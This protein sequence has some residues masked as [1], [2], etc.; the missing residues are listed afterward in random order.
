[1]NLISHP[2]HPR[3]CRSNPSSAARY[4]NNFTGQVLRIDSVRDVGGRLGGRS[5]DA[6]RRSAFVRGYIHIYMYICMYYAQVH[7]TAAA[8][9]K[10]KIIIQKIIADSLPVNRRSDDV[11]NLWCMFSYA[12]SPVQFFVRWW[13][14]YTL[15]Q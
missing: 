5:G 8:D 4:N 12:S 11:M 10:T 13:L 6:S 1:M 2:T 15:L 7:V 9:M 14:S 3:A